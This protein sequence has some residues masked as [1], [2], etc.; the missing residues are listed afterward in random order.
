[1]TASVS[2]PISSVETDPT[3]HPDVAGGQYEIPDTYANVAQVLQDRPLDGE[4]GW[5]VR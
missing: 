5:A 2:T 3:S 1:V 4:N